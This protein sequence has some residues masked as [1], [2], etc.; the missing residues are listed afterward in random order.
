M[1]WQ[2]KMHGS[3]VSANED[4]EMAG[5]LIVW[6]F[7]PKLGAEQAFEQAYGPRGVWARLFEQGDG[8]VT[9]ELNRDVKDPKRYLT[10]DLW[11]SKEAYE[12]FH[13]QHRGE[14]RAI[15]AAC[16]GLT[17]QETELGRF[18]RLGR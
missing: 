1:V 5:Y 14:Y 12:R 9:T 15:D 11:E 8:F 17:E 18:E 4:N 13:S 10:L 6:E 16:E 3:G 7:R 2:A